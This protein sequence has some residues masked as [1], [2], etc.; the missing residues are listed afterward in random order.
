MEDAIPWI[1]RDGAITFRDIV[2]K[3]EILRGHLR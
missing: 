2:S 1:A 3:L